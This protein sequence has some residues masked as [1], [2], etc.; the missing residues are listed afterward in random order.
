MDQ[1]QTDALEVEEIF[2]STSKFKGKIEHESRRKSREE[3]STSNKERES[4]E[5]KIEEM[6]KL[7]KN[8]SNKLVKLELEANNSPPPPNQMIPNRRFNP[9]YR[10]PTLQLL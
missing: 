9:Q 3:A 6:N 8:L 4:Q 10:K 7:I 1:I 5:Y 2:S